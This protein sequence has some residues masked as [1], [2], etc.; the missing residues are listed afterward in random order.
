MAADRMAPGRGRARQILA[1]H[2]PARHPVRAPGRS[3]QPPDPVRGA[4]AH[5]A[6]LPGAETG[7]RPWTRR[8]TR[9]ARLPPS[10]HAVHRGLCLPDRRAGEDSPPQP[11]TKPPINSR[12]LTFP[13]VVYPEAP[14]VR[15]ERHVANSIA[16]TRRHLILALATTLAR[17]PCCNAPRKTTHATP[18][19]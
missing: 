2:P 19:L 17:C 18:I 13:K 5:R 1:G 12:E 3:G 15:P 16:T 4:L 6:R 14:P 8:G 9:L 7:T 10:R 11:P